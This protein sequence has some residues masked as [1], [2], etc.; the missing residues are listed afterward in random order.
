MLKNKE[1]CTNTSEYTKKSKGEK[2]S[3]TIFV[4]L[5]MLFFVIILSGV[6]IASLNKQKASL[7]YVEK[8][9]EIYNVDESEYENI[10]NNVLNGGVEIWDGK[11]I[12]CPRFDKDW[13]WYIYNP[14]QLKFLADFINVGSTE[15]SGI[16]LLS[17]D[18]LKSYVTKSGYNPD[19][20]RM[21][22]DTIVYLMNDLDLGAREIDGEWNTDEN[23]ERKWMPI[24][25]NEKNFIANFD[26]KNHTVSGVYINIDR[27]YV[28]L[29]GHSKATSVF[30]NVTIKDSYIEASG[31]IG[32]IIG[33]TAIISNCH[34]INTTVVLKEV[35]SYVIGGVVGQLG[36]NGKMEKCSNTGR[37]IAK[38]TNTDYGDICGGL[39]GLLI[40]EIND[41]TNS[42]KVTGKQMK[43]GGI[44]GTANPDST[45][46]NC[47]NNGEISGESNRV[48]GIAGGFSDNGTIT[49]CINNGK[50]TGKLIYVGGIAGHT[51]PG[52][53]ISK[54]K[55]NG[56]VIGNDQYVAGIVGYINS[57]STIS[58]CE[59]NAT[60]TGTGNFVGGIFGRSNVSSEANK[61][62]IENCSNSGD[63]STKAGYA[64]GI[65]GYTDQYTNINRCTNTGTI[66]G[67]SSC[68]AGIV[69]YVTSNG[70]VTNSINRGMVTGKGSGVAGI[71]GVTGGAYTISNCENSGTIT[72]SS[73]YLGGI[74]GSCNGGITINQSMNSG[75]ING[76]QRYTG[77]IAGYVYT[78]SN[79]Q[80]CY[81]KGVVTGTTDV[82]EVIGYAYTGAGYTLNKLYYLT[83]NRGL[84]AIGNIADDSTQKI[85]EVTNNLTSYDDFITWIATQ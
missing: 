51:S 17:S 29:F 81:N 25:S 40:G 53:T 83:N 20:V 76:S 82:G 8:I 57:S 4:L 28:G 64:G 47:T 35:N 55:N 85:M 39:V 11:S 60:I 48:G 49:N 67:D 24:G 54:S 75:N 62:I 10:Y 33:V 21:T 44:V 12:E 16:L 66:N 7:E 15:T 38:G 45:I 52:V 18:D 70:E 78:N 27:N 3:I 41:C 63:V 23:N 2:G 19:G 71:V 59:N 56:D 50:I 9:A 32:G 74:A 58:E 36:A 84:K 69:G 72:S 31:Y 42:G 30:Q 37:I 46:I 65:S 73:T 6:Y 77:G 80:N 14:A 34:N 43:V 61:T 1:V 22:Q 26:G 5:S 79:V 13:N 68:I